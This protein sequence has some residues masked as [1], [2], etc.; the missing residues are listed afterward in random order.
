MPTI[1]T[2]V[3]SLAYE[4]GGPAD[5]PPVLL[6]H[7]WPDAP[8]GWR[9]VAEHLQAAGWRT[10]I[11]TLRG[12]APTRFLADETPRVAPGVALAQDAIDLLDALQ[13]QQVAVVGHDWGARAAYT[14]A[15]LFPQRVTAIVALALAYQ[16]KGRFTLPDFAQS[17]LF[18]Y[19]WF[20]CTEAGAAA[21]RQDPVGFA[22]IQ[23]DT[24]SPPGW[25]DEAEFTATAAYFSEP[26]WAEI[27][28]QAY[29]S[30]WLPGEATDPRYAALQKR[31]HTIEDLTTP[32]LM[33]QGGADT[34]DAPQESEGLDQYF[35]AGY[36]RLVLAGVGHF[37]HR[38]APEVVARHILAFL[39]S[40]APR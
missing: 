22:R 26:D 40:K 10:I 31:L 35:T 24:W 25:F 39:T 6:L 1:R 18:W 38:E 15:A 19:Q 21:V 9:A 34:C 33:L 14:L 3:L 16:P 2:E 11:P 32:T 17:R 27:T 8:R 29:R 23:W 36:Q 4:E 13:I 7:G 37:P 5:G 28:L 20:M 30:R 12:T